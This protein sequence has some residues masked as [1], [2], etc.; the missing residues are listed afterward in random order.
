MITYQKMKID[1]LSN[2]VNEYYKEIG[3]LTTTLDNNIS[4]IG[5]QEESITL[6]S[7]Q[8]DIGNQLSEKYHDSIIDIDTQG[9]IV[10]DIIEDIEVPVH[11]DPPFNVNVLDQ[12]IPDSIISAL[13]QLSESDLPDSNSD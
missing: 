13:N 10:E 3:I 8:L 9:S 11:A 7:H 4:I 12:V 1:N 6:L 5:Q 2:K